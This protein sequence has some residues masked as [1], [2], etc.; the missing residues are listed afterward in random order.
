ML[1]H[2]EIGAG[3]N[4][5]DQGGMWHG[6]FPPFSSLPSGAQGALGAGQAE[7]PTATRAFP[8][9]P[10]LWAGSGRSASRWAALETR[11]QPWVQHC[12]SWLS[13]IVSLP[14]STVL[15]ISV[16]TLSPK[17][18]VRTRPCMS[19]T[20]CRLRLIQSYGRTRLG[21]TGVRVPNSVP[22][23]RGCLRNDT[24]QDSSQ[25]DPTQTPCWAWGL[26]GFTCQGC[27][28][29]AGYFMVQ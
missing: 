25:C 4:E 17:G 14:A 26:A 27:V 19:R 6:A 11:A 5:F 22:C 29:E 12:R 10:S 20:D 2:E 8:R 21:R 16:E 9:A 7:P 13:S 18:C 23:H 3:T 15:S 24:R 1:M 28:G